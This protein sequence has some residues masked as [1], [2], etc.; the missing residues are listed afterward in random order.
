[1]ERRQLNGAASV[2]LE[3]YGATSNTKHKD[4]EVRIMSQQEDDMSMDGSED[5]IS[6]KIQRD[7]QGLFF[8]DGKR[9]I[10]FILTYEEHVE[11]K[12]SSASEDKVKKWRQKF[13]KNLKKAGI[14]MEESSVDTHYETVENEKKLIT[15]IK[16]HAPWDV[17]CA[18]AEDLSIR[19]PLQV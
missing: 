16:L 15:F 13:I 11:K 8:N 9:K 2:A 12:S 7:D 10:D 3:D 4:D 5:H 17:C 19:A 14:N 1:M 18:Y 6:I